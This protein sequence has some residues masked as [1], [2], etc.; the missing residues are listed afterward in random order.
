MTD[1]LTKPT[2]FAVGKRLGSVLNWERPAGSRASI[3]RFPLR[4]AR[5]SAKWFPRRAAFWTAPV[6][7]TRIG[8]RTF[9]KHWGTNLRFGRQG[10]GRWRS[11]PLWRPFTLLRTRARPVR[12]WAACRTP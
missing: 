6:S 2:V 10:E 11:G 1:R 8:T 4:R 9:G 12:R 3:T 7:G 5:P